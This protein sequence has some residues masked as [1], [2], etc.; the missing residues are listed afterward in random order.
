MLMADDYKPESESTVGIPNS[1]AD[2]SISTSA[3]TASAMKQAIACRF[4][5]AA[6]QYDSHA[7]I[8][9]EIA[10]YA[11]SLVASLSPSRKTWS[12]AIDIG[13]ATGAYTL[14]LLEY[15]REVTGL[16]LSEGMINYAKNHHAGN[17]LNWIVS[18][19]EALPIRNDGVDLLYSSMALQ[20]LT[21]PANVAR[22]CFRVLSSQGKGT[23]AVV[24]DGSL[25]ELNDSWKSIAQTSPVNQFMPASQWQSAF[26]D[27]GFSVTLQQKAF[28]SWHS[29]I[30]EVLH[31][32]KDIGAGV[33]VNSQNHGRLNKRKLTIFNTSYQNHFAIEG[34]LPLTWQIAF[35]SFCKPQS[36]NIA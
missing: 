2:S 5:E 21:S 29:N 28:T 1:C 8:Q 11:L 13:C 27:V 3:K 30:F 12:Q 7:I 34:R 18:D 19:A 25:R 17:R 36:E 15:A 9:R 16:D 33:V 32:I 10:D 6:A 14:R 24:V 4:G 26:H 23:I 35:L 22:E 31:S 20:W